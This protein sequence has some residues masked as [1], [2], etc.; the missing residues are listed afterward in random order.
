MTKTT[1][2]RETHA[3]MRRSLAFVMGTLSL[4]TLFVVSAACSRVY[5]QHNFSAL[6]G[7][8]LGA[9][10]FIADAA[11]LARADVRQRAFAIAIG[12]GT[13]PALLTNA[14]P[15]AS[16]MSTIANCFRLWL[17]LRH[18]DNHTRFLV[19]SSDAHWSTLTINDPIMYTE[20]LH[21][22]WQRYN[23]EEC[24]VQKNEKTSPN[25]S[26]SEVIDM[27]EIS[28]RVASLKQSAAP[29]QKPPR[30]PTSKT[31]QT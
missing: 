10:V 15:L 12:L 22:D 21:D 14:E 29:P 28:K 9:T 11:A 30:L 18:D 8:I 31:K 26:D 3:S 2:I 5:N 17:L 16:S 19:P 23:G 25:S 7:W 1:G 20:T 6:A 27:A 4:V 13:L 24:A